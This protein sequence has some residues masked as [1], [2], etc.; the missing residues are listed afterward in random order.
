MPALRIL[1]RLSF[2]IA[3]ALFLMGWVKTSYPGADVGLYLL[4]AGLGG[5]GLF[6]L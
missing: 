5:A 4:V 6:I 1:L 2:W 3:V